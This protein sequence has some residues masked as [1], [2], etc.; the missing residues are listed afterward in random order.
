MEPMRAF[1]WSTSQGCLLDLALF[2]GVS[3]AVSACILK[4]MS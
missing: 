4:L 1:G 2:I 3:L